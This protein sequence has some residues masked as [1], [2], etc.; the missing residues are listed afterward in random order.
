MWDSAADTIIS[1]VACWLM[2]YDDY[3]SYYEYE[4]LP[5][6]HFPFFSLHNKALGFEKPYAWPCKALANATA[7]F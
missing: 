1:I 6:T 4:L 3:H 5:A 7:H 2:Y